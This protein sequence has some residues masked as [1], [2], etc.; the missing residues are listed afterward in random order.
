MF[1]DVLSV[2]CRN[3][4]S[5]SMEDAHQQAW[6]VTLLQTCEDFR[7]VLLIESLRGCV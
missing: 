3:G 6:T 5:N 1:L 7:L 4:M 2:K